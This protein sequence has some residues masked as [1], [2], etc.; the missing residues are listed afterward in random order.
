MHESKNLFLPQIDL[1]CS[2]VMAF[3]SC[4]NTL[5]WCPESLFTSSMSLISGTKI[6]SLNL[7]YPLIDILNYNNTNHNIQMCSSKLFFYHIQNYSSWSSDVSRR[8]VIVPCQIGQETLWFPAELG[9][10]NMKSKARILLRYMHGVYW[11][12]ISSDPCLSPALE[13]SCALVISEQCCFLL[14]MVQNERLKSAFRPEMKKHW[15]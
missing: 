15:S 11:L 9:I 7:L 2:R 12:T 5:I 1:M 8:P 3:R 10:N 14:K 6:P 13:K 4:V